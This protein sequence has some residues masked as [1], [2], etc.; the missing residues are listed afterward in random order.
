MQKNNFFAGLIEV[1]LQHR[2]IF[3]LRKSYP[4][5]KININNCF[6]FDNIKNIKLGTNSVIGPFNVFFITDQI[7]NGKESVLSIGERTSI[8]EQNNIRVGGASIIIG[9][10][11]LISQQVSIVSSNHSIEKKSR[12]NTQ[13]WVNKGEIIIGNDVW[14]GCSSQILAGVNIGDG[15]V[16]AAGTV[17]TKNIPPYAIVA[18]VPGKIIGFRN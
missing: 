8:G 7:K 15:A 6:Y 14:V 1:N 13:P 5:S 9:S 17:V 12:I 10:D 18:G 11:C 4:K 2:N 3:E 16:I